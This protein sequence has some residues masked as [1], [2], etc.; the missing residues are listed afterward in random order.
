VQA[1]GAIGPKSSNTRNRYRPQVKAQLI[2]Q[3]LGRR[4][5]SRNGPPSTASCDRSINHATPGYTVY[6][7]V[8]VVFTAPDGQQ[9]NTQTSFTPEY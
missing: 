6:V 5:A 9:V 4:R 8:D 2:Q 7:D 1:N 3:N